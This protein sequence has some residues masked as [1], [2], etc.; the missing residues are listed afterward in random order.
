MKSNNVNALSLNKDFKEILT[1]PILDIAANFWEKDRYEAFKTCYK[2][3]RYVDNLIDER[4]ASKEKITETEKQKFTEKVNNWIS[5]IA[6]VKPSNQVQLIKTLKKFKIPFWPWKKLSEAMI[7]DLHHDGFRTFPVF[8]EYAEGAAVAPGSIFMHLCS[9]TNKNGK[10]YAPQFDI[11]K[12]SRPLALFAYL[13]HLIRDFQKDHNNNLNYFADDLIAK[14]NLTKK[15]LKEIAAGGKISQ[16]FRNL[17]KE[18]HN[19]AG[20][21]RNKARQMLDETSAYLKPPYL[22]SLEVLYSLY[23]QIFERIDVNN[24]KFTTEELNPSPKEI[25]ERISKIVSSFE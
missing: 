3:M 7:Y 11:K 19:F 20:H 25:K 21:Y 13:V 10:Y 15:T 12:A 6:N 5:L 23:L 1:N 4:K 2:S 8:L 24:G 16:N 14:H 9:V 18:H 22:L 17:I